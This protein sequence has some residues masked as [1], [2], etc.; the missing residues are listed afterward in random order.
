MH[1]ADMS[2]AVGDREPWHHRRLRGVL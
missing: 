2:A 1:W